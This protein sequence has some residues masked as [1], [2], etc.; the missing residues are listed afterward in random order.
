MVYA[1]NAR[2]A[3]FRSLAEI[4]KKWSDTKVDVKKKIAAH[5]CGV[6]TTGGGPELSELIPHK[7]RVAAVIRKTALSAS[8]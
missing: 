3:E 7:G 1:V 5:F 2:G 6:S 4:K 8:T